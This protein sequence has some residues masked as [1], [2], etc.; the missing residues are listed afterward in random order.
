MR[1]ISC[2]FKSLHP[3]QTKI[4][5]T[6]FPLRET[7][8]DDLF[9][10]KDLKTYGAWIAPSGFLAGSEERV[11]LLTVSPLSHFRRTSA[12]GNVSSLNCCAV[13]SSSETSN[14]I[15]AYFADG[16]LQALCRN[17]GANA[18]KTNRAA[19]TDLLSLSETVK[20]N[21]LLQRT[22]PSRAR[23]VRLFCSAFCSGAG[24]GFIA[25]HPL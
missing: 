8:S 13:R 17:H 22:H 23:P 18:E 9:V 14:K 25:R 19:A 5:R 3:H 6:G 7:G 11:L 20:R 1:A 15:G 12:Y 24:N 10:W 16:R 4:I 21:C 2:G